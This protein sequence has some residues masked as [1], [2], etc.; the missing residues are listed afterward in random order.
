MTKKGDDMKTAESK[1]YDLMA[2]WI[3]DAQTLAQ[4]ERRMVQLLKEQ[5]RDTRYACNEAVDALAR[6]VSQCAT[7]SDCKAYNEAIRN[8]AAACMNVKAV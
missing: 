4:L 5:D 8:A 6:T 2:N 1:V 3:T 7:A